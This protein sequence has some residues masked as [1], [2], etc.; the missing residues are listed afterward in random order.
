MDTP[1]S[2]ESFNLHPSILE[3][4]TDAGF[5]APT[6]IQ[7]DV[8]GPIIDGRDLIAKS[9]TGSGKTAAFAL[10][11]L[12]RLIENPDVKILVITPTRELAL[13][14]KE[15]I[16]FF[17]K[18]LRLLP[19]AVF[20]GESLTHQLKRLKQDNRVIVATPGRLL[21]LYRSNHLKT[22]NPSIVI[23]DEAD[24]MLNMGFLEDIQDI[25][26]YIPEERQT[27]LFS[28]T[29]PPEI[30]KLSKKLLNDPLSFDHQSKENTHTDI[31]QEYYLI[32]PEQRT[33]ALI[34]IMQFLMPT[35]SIVFCNTKKQVDELSA[36]LIDLGMPTLRLH[37]DMQQKER[38]SVIKAFRENPQGCLIAT[39]VAGR[40]INVPDVTH[41]FNFELPFSR[42]SY[43]HRI[44]RTGRAGNKGMAIT[45]ITNREIGFLKKTVN[46]QD[47]HLEF[48][49]LPQLD[50][51]KAKQQHQIL[52]TI[53]EIEI[54]HEA[55]NLFNTL[56]D[57]MPLEELSLRLISK[58]IQGKDLSGQDEL[59]DPKYASQ[60]AKPNKRRDNR[61]FKNERTKRR[62]FSNSK[63]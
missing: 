3:R 53:Q 52:A 45:L 62:R 15:E 28:A 43:T 17:A 10:P 55:K 1:S 51:I 40:G 22:F 16:A 37:G 42:E 41:V 14:V 49:Q 11:S 54:H 19:T 20:G 33:L 59:I 25:F 60:D 2:F 63:R 12:N 26:S 13:Q 24:E 29:M 48:A 4:I 34:R 44:G 36:K 23:L 27:L 32:K 56:N 47:R 39:D 18:N 9:Q 61:S 38:Q 5:T 6:P 57:L 21:D 30:R 58:H 50:Q 35:K 31:E 8:M 7:R 46:A